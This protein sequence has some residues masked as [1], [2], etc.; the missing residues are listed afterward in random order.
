VT[1]LEAALAEEGT[2]EDGEML[3]EVMVRAETS[4]VLGASQPLV[5]AG[6]QG[7]G[8]ANGRG[9]GDG[10]REGAGIGE[11]D[12]SVSDR[13]VDDVLVA[14]EHGAQQLLEFCG[15]TVRPSLNGIY[16]RADEFASSSVSSR[17]VYRIQR[18]TVLAGDESADEAAEEQPQSTAATERVAVALFFLAIW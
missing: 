4:E 14:V 17:P 18:P 10:T 8:A 16:E 11:A 3:E 12:V 13:Q 5:G 2:Q 7:N 1:D 9:D 15:C 6:A